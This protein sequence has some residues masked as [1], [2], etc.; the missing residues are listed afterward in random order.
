MMK[1]R[2]GDLREEEINHFDGNVTVSIHCRVFSYGI[3]Y[4]LLEE[5]GL[6]VEE[7]REVG[8]IET[9]SRRHKKVE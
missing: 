2:K 7:M 8:D 3:L 6:G 5:R 4:V 9:I 1:G